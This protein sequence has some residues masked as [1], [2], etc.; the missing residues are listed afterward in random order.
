MEVNVAD[1]TPFGVAMRVWRACGYF[2]DVMALNRHLRSAVV[3]VRRLG[4]EKI[5]LRNQ[6]TDIQLDVRRYKSEAAEARSAGDQILYQ[7]ILQ[8]IKRLMRAAVRVMTKI[9]VTEHYLNR[10]TD[11]TSGNDL[12]VTL[13]FYSNMSFIRPDADRWNKLVDNLAKR[14]ML[15]EERAARFTELLADATPEEDLEA[16]FAS[17]TD[18]IGDLGLGVDISAAPPVPLT[19]LTALREIRPPEKL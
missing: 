12:M 11:E 6:L 2:V 16:D 13:E 8:N 19:E 17:L 18:G 7:S 1:L 10:I 9:S 14:E 3:V 15:S 4:L 5:D